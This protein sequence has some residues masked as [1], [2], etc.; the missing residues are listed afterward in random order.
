MIFLQ[1]YYRY[2]NEQHNKMLQE[3]KKQYTYYSMP[4]WKIFKQCFPQSFNVFFT[5]FVTMAIFPGVYSGKTN[6]DPEHT[7]SPCW[8]WL[9]LYVVLK[10]MTILNKLYNFQLRAI[11]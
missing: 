2:H 4:Y 6:K 5:Y 1:R 8:L 3:K 7:T 9:R 11:I 10:T